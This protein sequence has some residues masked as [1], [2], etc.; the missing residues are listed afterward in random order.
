MMAAFTSLAL[1]LSA[2][3]GLKFEVASV[4][5][6]V[7]R[8][9]TAGGAAERTGGSGFGG[10]GCPTS[11]KVSLGRV[12]VRCA[13]L[14]VLIGYAFR[15]SPDRVTGPA[16]MTG[17][18]S[19]KFD[20]AA[21]IPQG[22]TENQVPELFQALLAD[23]FHLVFHRGTGARAIYALVVAKGGIKLKKASPEAA[24]TLAPASV[25]EFYGAAQTRTIPNVDGRGST[26]MISNPRMGTVRQ[27]GDPFEIQ[28][29]EASDISLAGL[30]DLL[31]TVAPV[32]T[33]M[34][35]MT[36]VKGRFQ[37]VLEVSLG[38]ARPGMVSITDMEAVVVNAFN[39]GLR[40]LGLKLERRRGNLEILVVDRVEKVPTAN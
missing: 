8:P 18:G 15:I 23:R 1:F 11:L 5:P 32:S 27:T 25:E 20:I 17:L 16:W 9:Q 31:D 4:K 35:D 29:W 34:I 2:A 19:P 24:N 7:P 12:D 6:S 26:I 36:A 13:T 33:P 21:T 28:R 38:A 39:D 22:A 10:G 14:P 40:K 3:A 37:M 30:A